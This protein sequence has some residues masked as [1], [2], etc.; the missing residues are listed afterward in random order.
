MNG[1][2]PGQ[3]SSRVALE[4]PVRTA[5]GS[6]GATLDW[7]EVVTLWAA[8]EPVA[9]GEIFAAD[10]LATRVTHRIIIRHRTDVEGVMRIVHRGRAL[11]IEAWRDPDETR[12]FLVLEAVEER[13]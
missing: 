1:F 2:D 3:L 7:E 4:R 5:D 8:I 12:R 13:P 11:C 10:R 9:A 6:G